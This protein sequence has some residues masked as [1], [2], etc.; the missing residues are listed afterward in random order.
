MQCQEQDSLTNSLSFGN[1]LMLEESLFSKRLLSRVVP[2]ITRMTSTY[3]HTYIHT[4]RIYIHPTL[5]I[6]VSDL[7]A[8]NP[9]NLSNPN[10]NQYPDRLS[11][12]KEYIHKYIHT[13]IQYIHTY[14]FN[15]ECYTSRSSPLDR[16]ADRLAYKYFGTRVETLEQEYKYGLRI[17]NKV[18]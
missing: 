16:L 8:Y 1:K 15:D 9:S 7:I 6:Y 17:V 12:N 18:Q 2:S 10:P 3:I 11:F 4:V 14:I 13:Y 5:K